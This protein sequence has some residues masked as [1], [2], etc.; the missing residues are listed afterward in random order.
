MTQQN[1]YIIRPAILHDIQKICDLNAVWQ[2]ENV[3]E[4]ERQFGYLSVKYSDQNIET[5]GA[6]QIVA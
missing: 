5:M 4:N 2:Y 6:N 3:P 1:D